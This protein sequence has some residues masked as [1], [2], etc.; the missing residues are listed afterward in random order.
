M[1]QLF[2]CKIH[3][4]L[5]LF[6]V[7]IMMLAFLSEGYAQDKTGNQ[8]VTPK[9]IM[10]EIPDDAYVPS[11]RESHATSPAYKYFS[12]GF[13]IVQVN[14]DIEG[15]NIVNDAANEP[16]IAF[17]INDPNKIA[18]GWRQFDDISN[19]FRQAGYRLY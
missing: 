3:Q 4:S 1:N 13:S 7:T 10:L 15:N 14:V 11:P 18:I 17:D 8:P 2:I 12:T 5:T 19:N 6:L 16:S 9:N